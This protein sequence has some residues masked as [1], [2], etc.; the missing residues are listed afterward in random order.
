[1]DCA[2]KALSELLLTTRST[3]V[4]YHMENPI[5]Q[6][7]H[8][9]LTFLATQLDLPSADLLPFSDWIERVCATSDKTADKNP[10]KK[11]A[12]FFRADFQHMAC[13]NVILGTE[14]LTK[15]SPTLQGMDTVSNETVANYVNYWRRVGF[16]D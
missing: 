16:L 4:V 13:G 10:A 12:R 9:T 3:D 2:A 11:L 14:R 8:D 5:R 1:M 7:W 6:S 15:I